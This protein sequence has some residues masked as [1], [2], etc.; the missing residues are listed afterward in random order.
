[1]PIIRTLYTY[2]SKCLKKRGYFSKAKGVREHKRLGNT[3]LD[4]PEFEH[5]Q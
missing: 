4:Y 2:V 3:E 1:M 5:R